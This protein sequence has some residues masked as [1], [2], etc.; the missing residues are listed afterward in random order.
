MAPDRASPLVAPLRRECELDTPRK[1]APTR[2]TGRPSCAR[3][4]D[5]TPAA[6]RSRQC[7]GAP[8]GP[9]HH[10]RARAHRS[11]HHIGWSSRP[12]RA[13]RAGHVRLGREP[14]QCDRATPQPRHCV[15]G[16]ARTT[17]S[18]PKLSWP[19][20][21]APRRPRSPGVSLQRPCARSC[22]CGRV[23]PARFR[24]SRRRAPV[25][26]PALKEHGRQPRGSV[27]D[28]TRTK[29]V[30]SAR[31]LTTIRPL[32]TGLGLRNHVFCGPSFSPLCRPSS[33]APC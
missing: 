22:H 21:A 27:G 28:A 6:R 5:D 24:Y 25:P 12:P 2:G 7:A 13:T 15:A 11:P 8:W 10:A 14:R 1:A 31:F 23:G 3:P 26:N 20:C 17:A 33:A 29:G 16:L 32:R 30:D 9:H 18:A 4:I 19:T